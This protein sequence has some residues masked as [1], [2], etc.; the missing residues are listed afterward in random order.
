MGRR[1]SR[2]RATARASSS[3]FAKVHCDGSRVGWP[4]CG[5]ATRCPLLLL[6]SLPDNYSG[7]AL[8]ALLVAKHCCS[9]RSALC[10]CVEF[11]ASLALAYHRLPILS[12]AHTAIQLDCSYMHAFYK[13]IPRPCPA[14]PVSPLSSVT[15]HIS[16]SAHSAVTSPCV[17]PWHH[18]PCGMVQ[19]HKCTW[20]YCTK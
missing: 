6:C 18:G 8:D 14:C 4:C 19:L 10:F 15:Q 12:T 7:T 16:D 13:V 3:R 11:A 9:G 1:S 17:F 20:L 5:R 2:C